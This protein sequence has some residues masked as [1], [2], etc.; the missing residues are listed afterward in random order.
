LPSQER[1]SSTPADAR[2]ALAVVR[3]IYGAALDPTA[4]LWNTMLADVAGFFDVRFSAAVGI[5]KTS[6]RLAVLGLIGFDG[7]TVESAFRRFGLQ[8]DPLYCAGL[9]LPAGATF[10]DG[11]VLSAEDCQRSPY[12]GMIAADH[13]LNHHL[14]GVVRNDATTFALLSF[15]RPA[16]GGG[17]TSDERDMLTWFMPHF[18]QAS[19]IRDHLTVAARD[20]RERK[21]LEPLLSRESRRGLVVLDAEGQVLLANAEARRIL[22]SGRTLALAR[23]RLTAADEPLRQAFEKARLES[24]AGEASPVAILRGPRNGGGLGHEIQVMPA[25]RPAGFDPLP[26]GSAT[27]VALIDPSSYY[28]LPPGRLRA[29]GLSGAEAR[30]CEALVRSGSLTRAAAEIGIAHGTARSHLKTIFGKLGVSTQIELVQALVSGLNYG[31]S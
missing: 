10:V 14:A 16:G 8:S 13:E 2:D 26:P 17:F 15:W 28:R 30:L 3:H 5:H 12:Y 7:A 27:L 24:L 31:E 9:R 18:A 6:D 25:A 19:Q 21:P 20:G 11:E 4:D 22:E 29:L 23:N 1:R